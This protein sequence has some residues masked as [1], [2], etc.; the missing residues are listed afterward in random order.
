MTMRWWDEIEAGPGETAYWR[1]GPTEVWATRHDLE[2]QVAWRTTGEPLDTDLAFEAPAR[3]RPVPEDAETVRFAMA[4]PPPTLRLAPRLADRAV[5][6]RPEKPFRVPSGENIEVYVS[7]PLWAAAEVGPERGRLHEIPLSRPS[8]TWFGPST[9]EG[10][11]CYAMRTVARLSLDKVPMSPQRAVTA[12]RLRNRASDPL[13]FER[14][15]LPVATLSLHADADGNLWTEAVRLQR[16]EE[17]DLA[18]LEVDRKP[19]ASAGETKLVSSA[20]QPREAN[21]IIRAFSSLF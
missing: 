1:V 16:Q 10:E 12:V 6:T 4:K 14:L 18:E 13:A 7:S 20:R 2:W 17:G 15:R 19:P 9:T 21:A 8:D 3:N 11:L 5:V